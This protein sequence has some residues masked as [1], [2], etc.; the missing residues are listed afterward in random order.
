MSKLNGRSLR[1]ILVVL[2]VFVVTAVMTAMLPADTAAYGIFSLI[3]AAFLIIYMLA[4]KRVVGSLLL[5]AMVGIIMISRPVTVGEGT[6]FG[7]AFTMFVD[8]TLETM[9]D[10]DP[11][12]IILVACIMG[13]I[14]TLI[15]KSGGAYAFG[16]WAASK[17]KTR[18]SALV[19]TW[20][21]GLIIF[22]DDYL[23]ALTVGGCMTSLTDKHRV[24][25][26]FLAYVV[27]STAAPVCVLIPLSTWAVFVG[28]IL[29]T[30]GWAPAGQG[31]LYFIKT[32]PF[33]FYGWIATLI[34]LLSILGVIPVFGPMK[35]A[36][37]RVEEGGPLAPPGSEK[38]DIH[39]GQSTEVPEKPRMI[40]MVLPIL[41]LLVST[42]A[43]DVDMF[44]G[45]VV[46]LIFMFFF[47]MGQGIMTAEEFCE[48]CIEGVK[49]MI[50]PTLILI[51]A[52]LFAKINAELHF[53]EF[54]ISVATA[55]VTPKLLPLI[56]FIALSITEFITGTNW[57]MYIIALPIVIPLAMGMNANMPLAV[58]AVLSAG[59]FGAHI[60][61]YAD[62]TVITSS[63]CGCDNIRHSVTQ[64]PYGLLGAGISALLFLVC[65]LI[66]G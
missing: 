7:N 2:A 63:A 22:L 25:R 27:D 5:T 1:T 29:E 15:E 64:L 57:G 13:S 46:T 9:M 33:N 3:P 8:M 11:A 17:A 45:V 14:I 40:N 19:W 21:L 59:V 20:I 26:E 60:C 28:K 53:T 4:T 18:K 55:L 42:V 61:F 44:K 39:A 16:L 12:W 48:Y 31:L 38:I 54:I 37:Q 35:K 32:I 36:F 50:Q 66:T 62:A 34:V 56:I 41:V 43:L 30:N 49:N 51:L 58:A 10:E 47:Y 52:F 6:W 24:P 65:G 23:N